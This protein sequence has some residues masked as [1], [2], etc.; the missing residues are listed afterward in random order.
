MFHSAGFPDQGIH[1]KLRPVRLNVTLNIKQDARLMKKRRAGK[2]AG[3][4]AAARAQLMVLAGSWA[5]GF[6]AG[7]ARAFWKSF[8]TSTTQWERQATAT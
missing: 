5:L 1:F 6:A 2:K 8:S 4:G 3:A 7:S